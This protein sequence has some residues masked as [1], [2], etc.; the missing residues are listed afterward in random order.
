MDKKIKRINVVNLL[1]DYMLQ[2]VPDWS[3]SEDVNRQVDS[4][5]EAELWLDDL[6]E[7]A[8]VKAVA[9]LKE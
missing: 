8:Q 1:R 9:K 3:G 5:W 7:D 4:I 2:E 6:I